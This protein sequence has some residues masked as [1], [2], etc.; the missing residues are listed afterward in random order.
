MAE[1]WKK[2]DHSQTLLALLYIA[3]VLPLACGSEAIMGV[4]NIS[5]SGYPVDRMMIICSTTEEFIYL[6]YE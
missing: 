6:Q 1:N 4:V 3:H 2:R 5:R